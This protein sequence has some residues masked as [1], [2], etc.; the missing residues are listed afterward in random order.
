MNTDPANPETDPVFSLTALRQRA[1]IY[2][3]LKA[4]GTAAIM[5]V[6]FMGYFAIL[7]NPIFSVV[8]VP[9][10]WIDNIVGFQLWAL[11][12]YLSLWIYVS[13]PA[14]VMIDR[15]Q[16]L[17]YGFGCLALGA[18]GLGIF[19]LWPTVIAPSAV[20]WSLH[21][22]FQ[23]LKQADSAGNACPSL[24]VAFAVFAGL[25]FIRIFPSIG[26]GKITNTINVLWAALIVHSTLAT[27][28]HV[29]IDALFGAILGAHVAC[30]N[31]MIDPVRDR[32]SGDNRALWAA[33]IIIK[34]SAI[35]LWTSGIPLVWCLTLFMSGGG[36]VIYHL[37]APNAQG[38]VRVFS[39]FTTA[40]RE[41]WLTLDDGP[42]PEDTPRIL[43]LLDQHQAKAT[44][45]LVGERAS[46]NL[47]LVAEIV[48][49]GHEI[50]YH[51]ETHPCA[52]F[53]CAS[54]AR[55]RRELDQPLV[56]L[57]AA[58]VVP[59]RFRSPVGITPLGLARELKRRNLSCI[60]WTIRSGDSFARTPES[61]AKNV[62]NRVRPGAIIL[63]HEGPPVNDTVRVQAISLVLA[64]LTA[65]GYRCMIPLEDSLR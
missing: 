46:R 38:L 30:L 13:L 57:T 29:A 10:T 39:T 41:V 50:G 47:E 6:F 61:V 15:R 7:R 18:V 21:P 44:F 8:T 3:P 65:Q 63:M 31:F 36:L 49:R 48:R 5:S 43:D 34:V 22:S 40:R 19:L 28:Q 54:P 42:H 60:G 14:S 52:M 33:V 26:A 27:H 62:H 32:F 35:L 51:T 56:S 17:S 2:V 55:I 9:T 24:H 64:D 25:W 4:F 12:A 59:R 37:F 45:F 53:W 1:A 23:F 20:D 11:P 16:L 58:G